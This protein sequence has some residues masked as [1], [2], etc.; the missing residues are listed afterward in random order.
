ML[1]LL[2]PFTHGIDGSAITS[3][4][5]LAQR[6][7][8]TLVLLSLI[9]VRERSGRSTIRWEDIQQ[10]TDILE[11]T[12]QKAA[13][14]E[15]PIQCVELR[16]QHPVQSIRAFAREMECEGIILFVRGGSGVLL[17]THEVKQLLED[18]VHSMYIANLPISRPWA[19]L[20]RWCSGWLK[21][22]ALRWDEENQMNQIYP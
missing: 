5:K 3:A 20:L 21:N 4:L 17:A 9:Q 2:L 7:E 14:M 8:A 15:V 11:F 19:S 12:R 16:S 6:R 22:S 18:R 1:H 10:S 13:R